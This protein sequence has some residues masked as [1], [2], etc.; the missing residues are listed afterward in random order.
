MSELPAHRSERPKKVP[1]DVV[2]E[3]CADKGSGTFFN[4]EVPMSSSPCDPLSYPPVIHRQ[5]YRLTQQLCSLRP[6]R[7]MRGI[8][9]LFATITAPAKN[10]HGLTAFYY[11][12]MFVLAF[13]TVG[14]ILFVLSH[15]NSIRQTQRAREL[16][17]TE[18]TDKFTERFYL[19]ER[20]K[21]KGPPS[22]SEEWDLYYDRL[23]GLHS[24]EF[25]FYHKGMIERGAYLDW[26]R[27]RHRSFNAKETNALERNQ[28]ERVTKRHIKETEFVPF[29][30]DVLYAKNEDAIDGILPPPSHPVP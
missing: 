7:L 15:G 1:R 14:T 6:N 11:S 24:M 23:Y 19:L 5:L 30:N 25:H 2:E 18:M 4:A 12:A 13:F 28:W 9:T 16:N 10:L 21:P 20:D 26:L 27:Y 29:M 22:E 3:F 17:T 8:E